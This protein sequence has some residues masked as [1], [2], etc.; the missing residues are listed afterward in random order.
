MRDENGA[1]VLASALIPFVIPSTLQIPDGA[2]DRLAPVKEIAQIG[3]AIGREFSYRLLEAA[4]PI[5]GQALQ[6][7]SAAHGGRT[8]LGRG[9]PPEATYVFKHALVQDAAYGSLLRSRRQR[10]HADIARALEGL[11]ADQVES[12]PATIAH[13]YTEAGLPEPAARNWLTAAELALS[14][15]AQQRP[16]ATRRRARADTVPYG[17]TGPPIS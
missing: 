2:A 14:R 10:I 3:A 16:T 17:S 9:A 12:A 13:H 8:D 15:S 11:F 6:A 4:A 7:L 5:Q 1:Y